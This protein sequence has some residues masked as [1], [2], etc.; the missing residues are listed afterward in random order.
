M[1]SGKLYKSFDMTGEFL[2]NRAE[3]SLAKLKCKA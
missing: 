2:R 3:R 1:K